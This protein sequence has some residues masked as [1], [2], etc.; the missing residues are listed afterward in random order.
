VSHFS[1]VVC[2]DDPAKLDA[3]M[4]PY[5][6]NLEDNEHPYWDYWRVG[7][8]FSYYFPYRP[9]FAAKVIR[10]ERGWD[11]PSAEP[12][13]C[14]GGPKGA[15]D[16]NRLRQERADS[17]RERHA[18]FAALIAGTPEAR[19]W[20][21]F[22]AERDAGNLTIDEAREM[23]HSQPRIRAISQ[24]DFR[25]DDD[26]LATYSQPVERYVM[27][28]VAQAVPGFATLT[29]DGRWMAPGVMGWFAMTDATDDTRAGYLEVANAYIESLPDEVYLIVTD[30]HV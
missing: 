6:E 16:L 4:A 1:V 13:H 12:M 11:S 26:P 14:D 25:W 20:K 8:R 17:A 10:P 19:S 22:L 5:D 3:V 18:E 23:Y 27:H 28:A 15:L 9:E 7:G 21:Q 30:C 2:I 29:T 24:T